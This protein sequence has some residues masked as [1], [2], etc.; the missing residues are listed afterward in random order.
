MCI[1]EARKKENLENR[2]WNGKKRHKWRN[3]QSTTSDN[4]KHSP[5]DYRPLVG[6]GRLPVELAG[7]TQI[8]LR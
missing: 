4:N 6:A 7:V 5:W 1:T 3:W 2:R 8:E